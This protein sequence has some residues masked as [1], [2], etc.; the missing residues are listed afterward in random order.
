M[1][2]KQGIWVRHADAA[3]E[4]FSDECILNV[5]PDGSLGFTN[6]LVRRAQSA[7]GEVERLDK[8]LQDC[9]VLILNFPGSRVNL[10]GHL[11]NTIDEGL[12]D[13][14]ES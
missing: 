9:R 12:K 5:H 13:G 1:S 8:V 7:E 2:S 11:K 4:F 3:D 14:L 6:P 10:V